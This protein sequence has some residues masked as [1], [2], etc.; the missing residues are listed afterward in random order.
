MIFWIL[1]FLIITIFGLSMVRF[2]FDPWMA[3]LDYPQPGGVAV[4]VIIFIIGVA[5]FVYSL[6]YF[7]WTVLP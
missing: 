5:G 1:L 4:G 2:F 7:A 3:R 6:L